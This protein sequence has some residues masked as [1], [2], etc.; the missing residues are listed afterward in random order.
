MNNSL[1]QAARSSTTMGADKSDRNGL[2]WLITLERARN[3][4]HRWKE[5]V[6]LSETGAAPAPRALAA[7]VRELRN[8]LDTWFA[9]TGRPSRGEHRNG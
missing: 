2:A 1:H 6:K 7:E 4:E 9:P 3:A 5:A 8:T